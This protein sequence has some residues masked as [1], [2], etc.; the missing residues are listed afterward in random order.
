MSQ[1]PSYDPHSLHVTLVTPFGEDGR[2]VHSELGGMVRELYAPHNGGNLVPI[3]NAEA[4]EFYTLSQ[5]ERHANLVTAREATEGRAFVAG[6]SGITSAEAAACA[7]R[8]LADGAS[9]L[10]ILPPFGSSDIS[11]AWNGVTYPEVMVNYLRAI[12]AE[13]GDTPF[14]IHPSGS[15]TPEYGLG[16]PLETVRAVIDAVPNVAGWKMT[17]SYEGFR[18]VARFLRESAPHVAIL[19]SSAVRYHENLANDQFDGACSGSF[20]YSL[21]PMLA[22]ISAWRRGDFPE[23]LRIW[24]SGL[25]K[26][27][28]YVYSDYARLHTR[29]KVGAYLCG[30]I[31]SP[32]LRDPFPAPTAAETET[33]TTLLE[34]AGIPVRATAGV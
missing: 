11:T 25:A 3:I 19:P 7:R 14:V 1:S 13:A 23:A 20:C 28:E 31:S 21:S 26:L 33:M 18:R 15:R 17:Y 24:K 8:A 4:G 22:H 29:Y 32:L 10:F 9:G 34:G 30:A 27:H 16:W 12:A 5:D 6:V 2:V